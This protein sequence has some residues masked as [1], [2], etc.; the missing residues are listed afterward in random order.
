MKAKR[1]PALLNHASSPWGRQ[2]GELVA[3]RIAMAL[4]D[5]WEEANALPLPTRAYDVVV[6]D[7]DMN[8]P[9]AYLN[10]LAVSARAAGV[11]AYAQAMRDEGWRCVAGH[12]QGDELTVEVASRGAIYSTVHLRRQHP[13]IDYAESTL[14]AT[15]GVA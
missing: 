5:R 2:F 13:Q 10:V 15:N 3:G 14:K 7:P 12:P 11:Q 4:M 1:W 8:G 9:H 6:D